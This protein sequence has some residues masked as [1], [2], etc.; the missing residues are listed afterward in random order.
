M[1]IECF[2]S[3][4]LKCFEREKERHKE[5]IEFCFDVKNCF[6]LSKNYEN[7]PFSNE[8]KMMKIETLQTGKGYGEK[9]LLKEFF[10]RQWSESAKN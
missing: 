5:V 7:M 8:D 4:V 3:N 9:K 6:F 1:S 10:D 2:V